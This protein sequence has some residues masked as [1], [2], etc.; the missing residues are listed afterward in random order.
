MRFFEFLSNLALTLSISIFGGLAH[1]IHGDVRV[2]KP[3]TVLIPISPARSSRRVRGFQATR[4]GRR[5]V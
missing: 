1:L 4:N 2:G 5:A 3:A